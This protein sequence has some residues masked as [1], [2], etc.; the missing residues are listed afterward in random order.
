VAGALASSGIKATAE[1]RAIVWVDQSGFY[2]LPMAVRTWAPCGRTPLP[3]VPLTHDHLAA[4]SGITA[5][6]RLLMQTQADAFHSLDVA[7]FLRVLLR[8]IKGKLLVIWDGAPIHRGQPIKDFLRQGGARRVHLEQ[9]PG[10][11]PELNPDEG[12]WNYL[13][14][15]EL[16]NLCCH[17]LRELAL[18]LRRAKER[19][20]HKRTVIQACFTQAGY[21]V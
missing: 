16:G 6:G 14:R 18:A 20:R 21:H 3:R 5:D 9:L 7:R 15:V 2:L 19:L 17:D 4:I 8:K 12:I 1:G 13:K 10:Y 11:A